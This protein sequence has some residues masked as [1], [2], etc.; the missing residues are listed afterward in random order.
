[1]N[2]FKQNF[3][4]VN[5]KILIL[6][7]ALAI[8]LK[9]F[10][11]FE[12][13]CTLNPNPLPIYICTVKTKTPIKGGADIS[14]SGVTTN[15][16][17]TVQGA[18][19]LTPTT[20]VPTIGYFRLTT[21]FPNP[22]V[23]CE[24]IYGNNMISTEDRLLGFYIPNPQPPASNTKLFS[25][26]VNG[27]EPSTVYYY[28]AV[29][30]GENSSGQDAVYYGD[31]RS[32][33][34]MPE[35]CATP[36]DCPG[37]D[38]ASGPADEIHPKDARLNGAYST[39]IMDT[40]SFWF[41]Y[42]KDSTFQNNILSTPLLEIC[43]PTQQN[44][45]PCLTLPQSANVTSILG[46]PLNSN[47]NSGCLESDTTYYFRA[48]LKKN[49]SSEKKEGTILSFTTDVDPDDT[50]IDIPDQ[51]G[52]PCTTDADCPAGQIC[53]NNLCVTPGGPG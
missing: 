30:S 8:G 29:T 40:L 51:P 35:G 19:K 21:A 49:G 31:V 4:I 22:P 28:C 25:V 50:V 14:T 15:S 44:P 27:L 13:P 10:A 26:K 42:T 2:L 39:T 34:K 24:Q 3:K 53:Q 16:F 12:F 17:A 32:F 9:A 52:L 23:F 5:L 37:F 43:K 48:V 33:Q 1:M 46:C 38:V 47:N 6:F 41:E 7:F 45:N 11:A 18:F 36:A 20:P